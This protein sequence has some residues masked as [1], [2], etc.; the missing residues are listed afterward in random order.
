MEK[1]KK[2]QNQEAPFERMDKSVKKKKIRQLI[3]KLIRK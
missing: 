2:D 1:Y 3:L